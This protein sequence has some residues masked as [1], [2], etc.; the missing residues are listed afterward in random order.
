MPGGH[1]H[2]RRNVG[3]QPTLVPRVSPHGAPHRFVTN[4]NR[5]RP[6]NARVFQQTARVLGY[7]SLRQ[8][9]EFVYASRTCGERI[10]WAVILQRFESLRYGRELRGFAVLANACLNFQVPPALPI[11]GLA[12]L[13]RRLFRFDLEHPA[14][15][16][17]FSVGRFLRM[18][19][20][21]IRIHPRNLGRTPR[22]MKN[23]FRVRFYVHLYQEAR[24]GYQS[25]HK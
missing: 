25:V 11:S 7:L 12:R 5:Q 18:L 22:T 23:L 4:V 19:C 10:D 24:D 2:L 17:L 20:W 3:K 8:L 13:W 1:K 16:F 14:M 15:R 21:L 6:A 9:F